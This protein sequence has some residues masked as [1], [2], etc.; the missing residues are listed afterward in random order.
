MATAERPQR[1][2]QKRPNDRLRPTVCYVTQGTVQTLPKG[3]TRAGANSNPANCGN[4][5][6]AGRIREPASLTIRNLSKE[7]KDEDA[8]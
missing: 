8:E 4:L 3:K 5:R 7:S 6:R 1:E 2:Q